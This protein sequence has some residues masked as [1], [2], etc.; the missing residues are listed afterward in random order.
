MAA[1]VL[2]LIVVEAVG[3][4]LLGKHIVLYSDNSPSVHWVQQLAVNKSA[5]AMQLIWALALQLQI[6]K[7]SPLTTLHI[8]GDKN[9]M[10]DIPSQSFGT[11]AK[12][13]C[14]TNNN[15]LSCF[16]P[17]FFSPRRNCGTTSASH[18][19]SV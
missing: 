15:F 8:A 4:Q 11:P 14:T 6:H 16:T 10:T 18:P 3:G 2:L 5:A 9:S 12:W 17:C 7:A 1:L 13:H 19:Q